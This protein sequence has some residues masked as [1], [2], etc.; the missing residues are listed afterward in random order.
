MVIGL[1]AY[2]LTAA[3]PPILNAQ[4]LPFDLPLHGVLGGLLGVGI[5]AFVVTGALA[6]RDGGVDLA[7]RVCGGGSRS[8]G[9]WSRYSPF[10]SERR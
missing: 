10:R 3:I 8:A 1:G 5:G 7:Q 6:G 2:F 9:I 4:V